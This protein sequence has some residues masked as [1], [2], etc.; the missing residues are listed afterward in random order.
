M[1]AGMDARDVLHRRIHTQRLAG[2][3][4][5]RPEDMVRSLVGVQSQDYGNVR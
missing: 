5:A 1:L 2:D 3:P 4:F